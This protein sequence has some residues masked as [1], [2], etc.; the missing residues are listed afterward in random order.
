MKNGLLAG[1]GVVLAIILAFWLFILVVKVTLK[2]I[3][4]AIIVGLGAAIYF[5]V[6]NKF[7]GGDAR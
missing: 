7:G 1:L 4:L 3:G 5:A 6:R 2:L